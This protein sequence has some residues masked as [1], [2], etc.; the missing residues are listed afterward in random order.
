MA[1][2]GVSGWSFSE[3]KDTF[4]AGV[5][6]SRW[7]EH[8]SQVLSTVEVNYTFRRIMAETTAAKWRDTVA[9]G[10]RF[11]VKAH[12]RI[13][14]RS[15]LSEPQSTLPRFFDSC[16]ELGETLGPILF[17]LP[18]TFGRDDERLDR[19]LSVLPPNVAAALEFRHPSWQ[20]GPV[21]E[22]LERAGVA[23]VIAETDER[24]ATEVMTAPFTYLRLRKTTYSEEDLET[25]ASRI[26]TYGVD[27]WAYFKHETKSTD[28]A[29]RL[30]DLLGR[31]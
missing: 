1:H 5:P 17:Q 30:A 20:A 8:Y 6:R 22:R 15:R 10:F 9:P 11:A 25:W 28:Y 26:E 24:P 21:Y 29:Q 27:S 7:L 4:Y 14:H 23:V 19:F 12:Q 18:P 3:W 13:T 16:R 2:V 31:T